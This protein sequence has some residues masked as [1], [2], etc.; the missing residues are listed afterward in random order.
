MAARSTLKHLIETVEVLE[1]RGVA[2]VSLTEQ[3]E[4]STPGGRL[5]FHVLGVLA[6]FERELIREHTMAGLAA[7]WARGRVGGGPTVWTV[8]EL[9][10]SRLMRASGEYDV[11]SI[12]TALGGSCA[13]VHRALQLA[14]LEKEAG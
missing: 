11:S 14:E 6:E 8:D 10:T 5:I 12:A 9:R 1:A 7:A 2:F 3:I 13:A 4:T